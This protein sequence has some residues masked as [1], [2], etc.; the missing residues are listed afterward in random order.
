MPSQHGL[1][2]S[3][4]KDHKMWGDFLSRPEN[5][6]TKSFRSWGIRATKDRVSAL[7][8]VAAHIFWQI[9]YLA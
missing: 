5:S 9:C 8:S 2:H 7:I 4:I 6:L 3:S 1:A